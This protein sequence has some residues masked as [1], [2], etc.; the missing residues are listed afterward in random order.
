MGDSV[1]SDGK[2]SERER[3]KEGGG[4]RD[5]IPR[6]FVNRQRNESQ[7]KCINCMR[8]DIT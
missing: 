4:E 5:N 3:E 2:E 1:R 8:T 7:S 6:I